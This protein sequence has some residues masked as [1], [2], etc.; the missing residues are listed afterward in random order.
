MTLDPANRYLLAHDLKG[1]W[2]LIETV[3]LPDGRIAKVTGRTAYLV[4]TDLGMHDGGTLTPVKVTPVSREEM[5]RLRG[6]SATASA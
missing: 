5:L 3:K 4:F 6:I 2:G 1:N